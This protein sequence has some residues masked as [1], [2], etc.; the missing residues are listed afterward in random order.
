MGNYRVWEANRKCFLYPENW[1]ESERDDR[2]ELEQPSIVC[3]KW[4][5]SL[6]RLGVAIVRRPFRQQT[7]TEVLGLA[8][9]YPNGFDFATEGP[10]HCV[11]ELID[12]TLQFAVQLVHLLKDSY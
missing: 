5:T 9:C 12:A 1:I 10:I 3:Q 8:V 11:S 7:P 6:Y 2:V 4:G